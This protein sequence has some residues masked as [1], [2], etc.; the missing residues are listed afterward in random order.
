MEIAA[1]YN[2][3]I[4][5]LLSLSGVL[6]AMVELEFLFENQNES[7][8][9]TMTLKWIVTCLTILS[10]IVLTR[11]HYLK[12]EI[13]KMRRVIPPDEAF[14]YSTVRSCFARSFVEICHA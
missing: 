12:F 5:C 1:R 14:L 4:L 10:L 8:T 9:M 6:F 13:L 11:Y 7:N 2:Y 3:D